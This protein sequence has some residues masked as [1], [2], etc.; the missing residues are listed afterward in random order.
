MNT[1][2]PTATNTKTNDEGT[3]KSPLL[4]VDDLVWSDEILPFVGVE[5][6]AFVG[7]VSKKIN[8]AYKDYCKIELQKNPRKVK[9]NPARHSPSRSLEIKDTLYS[10]TFFNQQRAELWLKGKS[11]SKTL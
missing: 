2:T 6:Y 7:V 5:Q 1:V 4:F 3:G 8:K 10:E 11:S 9:D